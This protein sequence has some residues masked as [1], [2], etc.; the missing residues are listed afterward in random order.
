MLIAN[1]KLFR[2]VFLGSLL[3]LIPALLGVDLPQG[4]LL[5][6]FVAMMLVTGIPHGATDHV[7]H[8]YLQGGGQ[9]QVNWGRFLSSYLLL[10]LVYGLGWYFFPGPSLLLFLGISVYHF[11]QSQELYIRWPN[12]SWKKRILAT[13]WGILVLGS[14]LLMHIGEVGEVLSP[15]VQVPEMLLQADGKDLLI[16]LAAPASTVAGLWGLS[17]HKRAMN[18]PEL[19]REI[20]CLGLLMAVFYF[21]GLWLGFAL[22]FGVW[23]SLSSMLAEIEEF[24][25]SRTFSWRHFFL[26]AL[27]FTLISIAGV[28][29]LMLLPLIWGDNVPMVLLFFIAIS[30]LTLPHTMYMDQFYRQ[31]P[32]HRLMEEQSVET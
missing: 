6:I 10:M 13:A 20:L 17:L 4:W 12:G 21:G 26:E 11:G 32:P 3:F 30:V 2:G 18:I 27:P 5:G 28:G 15:I 19:I 29:L 24:R 25:R 1:P 9:Q 14:L 16:W 22:Y 8:A 31:F 7:I 23:H